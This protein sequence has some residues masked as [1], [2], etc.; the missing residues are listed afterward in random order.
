M[1]GNNPTPTRASGR[2]TPLR[3]ATTLAATI[4]LLLANGIAAAQSTE[5]FLPKPPRVISTV[6]ANGD[7]NPYGVAFVLSTFQKGTGPLQTSDVLVSNF[8][9]KAN[10]Q[11]TGTTI[12]RIPQ[13]QDKALPFFHGPAGLGLTTALGLLRSGFVI[14][15]NGPTTD[16]T[17]A[18]AKAGSL[19]VIDNTGRLVQQVRDR[20]I[21]YPWDMTLVDRGTAAV[22]FVSNAMTG[23]VVRLNFNVTSSGLTLTSSTVVASGYTH[24][25]DPD[26]LFVAP[27]GLVYDASRDVLYVASSGDNA[28]YAVSRAME[29][30]GSSGIGALVYADNVHLHGALAMV[31]APNGHLVVSN[32]DVVNGDT[33]QT[34]EIVEFTTSGRFVKELQMDTQPGGAFGMAVRM[35][36]DGSV[37]AAVDDVNSTVSIWRLNTH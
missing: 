2:R 16:G 8:N 5:N 36:S 33:T 6:P 4:A 28:V 29:R 22:A 12:V 37:F 14:V 18:T 7:V 13:S 24:R 26:A 10:Q 34:S 30:G 11:G 35:S 15:G 19:L 9:N 23:N 17:A 3:L 32:N 21:Q 27:T 1:D 20:N 25:A 31:M